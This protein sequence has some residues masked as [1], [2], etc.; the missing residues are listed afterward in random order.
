MRWWL[1]FAWLAA[2]LLVAD[3]TAPA[4]EDLCACPECDACIWVRDSGCS[5]V[6]VGGI[7]CA[8]CAKAGGL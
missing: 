1:E 8:E 4:P 7:Y 3:L 6:R 2:R 5:R